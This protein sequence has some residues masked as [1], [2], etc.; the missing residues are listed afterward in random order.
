MTVYL[1]F[2][3]VST[4]NYMGHVDPACKP[5]LVKVIK[6]VQYI[7]ACG[8]VWYFPIQP[9]FHHGSIHIVGQQQEH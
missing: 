9:Y 1:K 4:L 3:I 7:L 5:T 6:D 2:A 8:V